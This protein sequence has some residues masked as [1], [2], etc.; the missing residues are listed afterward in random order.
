MWNARL[1]GQVTSP[2]S[3]SLSN[4]DYPI[5]AVD[6]TEINEVCDSNNRRETKQQLDHYNRDETMEGGGTITVAATVTTT[7][8]ELATTTMKSTK[9]VLR[10]AIG[11]G[12]EGGFIGIPVYLFD[13]T[14]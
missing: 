7:T 8:T 6:T 12:R 4:P 11:G 5:Y 1:T 9:N 3:V 10:I 14:S 2:L 13:V